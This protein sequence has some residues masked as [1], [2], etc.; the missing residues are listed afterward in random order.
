MQL[1]N[2]VKELR[3]MKAEHTNTVYEMQDKVRAFPA[4]E[5]RLI[6]LLN[7]LET[8][9]KHIDKLPVDPETMQPKFRLTIGDTV[10]TDRKEAA[11]AFED[12]TYDA[13]K[14]VDTPVKIGEF[15]GFPLS[16][17]MDSFSKRV[18]ASLSGSVTHR[19]ELIGSFPHN[20]K[21]LESALNSVYD[22]IRSTHNNLS[23]LR[24]DYAEAEKLAVQTFP[25]DAELA[26][27]EERLTTLTT[28]L[29]EAAAEAKKNKPQQRT[30][31]FDR[32]KLKKEAAKSRAAE[33]KQPEKKK[34]QTL[35]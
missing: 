19:A 11:Q 8:D 31:Y 33:K 2:E 22:R 20:L 27:K 29:N 35:E 23:E 26:Q 25:R 32:A 12:A 15:Q 21:R 13:I 3:L 17:Q 5:E 24:I 10:Y 14:V 28:E 7:G 34:K 16:V 18:T 9:R 6:G 4:N 30:C 1:D